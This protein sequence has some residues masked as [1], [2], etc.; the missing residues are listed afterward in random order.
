MKL[1]IHAQERHT[2]NLVKRKNTLNRPGTNRLEFTPEIFRLASASMVTY[3][4]VELVLSDKYM[5]YIY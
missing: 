5:G 1:G 4:C 2:V 3:T